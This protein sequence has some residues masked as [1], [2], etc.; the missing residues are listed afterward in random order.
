MS[1]ASLFSLRGAG[2][3]LTLVLALPL[4]AESVATAQTPAPLSEGDRKAWLA[5]RDQ[6]CQEA[7]LL[8]R[9]GKLAEAIAAREKMLALETL[10]FGEAHQEVALSWGWLAERD[11]RL[12]QFDRAKDARRE[13][14]R[15]KT[16]LLGEGHWQTT[17]ARLALK[18]V[19]FLAGLTADRRRQVRQ[20]A[21]EH[22]AAFV[23]YREGKYRDALNLE[24]KSLAVRQQLLGEEHPDTAL[25][26]NN[27]AASYKSLGEHAKAEPLYRQSL[28]I[29]KR[30]LG[31]EHPETVHSLNNLGGLY[32]AMADYAKAEP[33]YRRSLEIRKRVLGEEH[34]DTAVSLNNLGALYKSMGAY[35]KAE[36]LFRQSLEIRKRVQGE[37][38]PDTAMSLS[39]L[40]TLYQSL[41]DYAKAELLIRQSLEIRKRVQGEENPNTA[42]SLNNL[43]FLY[44][45]MGDYAKAESL[46]RESLEITKRVVGEEHSGVALSLGNLGLLY[47]SMGDHARAEPLLRQS[48]EI[49]KRVV[50]NEHPD[51]ATS[52]NNLGFL[53]QSMGDD[54]KA[55]PLYRQSLEIYTRVLGDEHP[56]TAT[57]LNNL[58]LFWLSMGD[59]E[60]AE[61][62][63]RQS[64][65][66]RKRVLGEKH[67][68]TAMSLNNLG[69]LYQSMG[70]N[71]KAEALLR[72]SLEIYKN[73]LG[74]DHPNT[75]LSLN[76]L[77]SLHQSMGEYMKAE[78]LLRQALETSRR[79]LE[80][81]AF[82]QSERQQLAMTADLK[83]HLDA[84]LSLAVLAGGFDEVALTHLVAWK[85]M[86]LARQQAARAVANRPE[87]QPVFAELQS[88][89]SQLA[90]AAFST[91]APGGQEI[92]RRR[93]AE[94]SERKESLER[95]LA[96]ESAAFR[97]ATRPATLDE[98]RAALPQDVV[99]VDF[100]EYQHNTP[101]SL[102]RAGRFEFEQRLIAFV[103]SKNGAAA[104]IDLGS[105][106][107]LS[108]A[109]D[110]WRE[111]LGRTA[112]SAE[113]GRRLRESLWL[114]I[115]ERIQSLS[116]AEGASPIRMVLVSPDGAMSNL[117]LGALPGQTPGSYL[118][119][120]WAIAAV[121]SPQ[122]LV[123]MFRSA[124]IA[125]EPEPTGGNVLV[126]GGVD[127][128]SRA[129]DSA[130]APKKTFLTQRAP[131][132]DGEGAFEPLSGT[133]GEL[134]TIERMYRETFGEPGLKTL[135]GAAATEDALRGQAPGYLYLHLATHG[136]FASA[137]FRSALDR[138]TQ[139]AR[140]GMELLGS[141]AISG[142]HPGLLSGL[143]LAGANAP[144]EDDDGILT[145]EEVATLNLSR[146]DLVVLSACE[147]GLGKTA[148]GEG[149][150]GLQ[151]AFHGAGAR[152]VVA[153]LWKVDDVATRDLME[154]FYENLWSRDM[155]KLQ[156]LREAQLWMLRERG[157]RGLKPLEGEETASL[158]QR[159]PPY[160]WAPFVLSGDWR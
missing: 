60:K 112:E 160:Y 3:L 108:D 84:Y 118:L 122:A 36:P 106:A 134:A 87:L 68:D 19:E 32:Q 154:R 111:G 23:L 45:S 55:E 83:C 123:S 35:A 13:A 135:S 75:T 76:N 147:T 119:E 116:R 31:E 81:A 101:K 10:L 151:R 8:D 27:L 158:T 24:A 73:V 37:E 39:N 66:I 139:D 9:Q 65:E 95:Q 62:L 77:G 110:V 64:L 156:A 53:W 127:Y 80:L 30:V 47:A 4:G 58:G 28:E 114:P 137:K 128:D 92:W 98:V 125:E 120:E 14:L 49:R 89:C 142:Y 38:H 59:D 153:S 138:S 157:P 148:G 94:L 159:L 21:I 109:I 11:E 102:D 132:E 96:R 12:E 72:Q 103:F 5:E 145:A 43:G 51:T 74:Q 44:Q 18:N 141:H 2:V 57:S 67:P 54:A 91:P 146:A 42:V 131:R 86:V 136:F 1:E 40:G 93:I 104:R 25:S 33:L 71:A 85:G 140:L 126:L 149:L 61:P 130:P 144:Q 107:T 117:P 63:Y 100:L 90:A 26:L 121:P 129:E 70:D 22:S 105:L 150:L 78:P 16:Q 34:L 79:N 46:Y 6:L 15:I 82:V 115:E 99:L 20:A 124:P 143:A 97:E 29:R 41:G 50:G 48:L 17:D 7:S 88:V 69:H 113:A 155:G 152:T 133:R 56:D 52:L